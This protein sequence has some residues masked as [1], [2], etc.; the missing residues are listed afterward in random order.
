MLEGSELTEASLGPLS[1][2][3]QAQ[4]P[5]ELAWLGPPLPQ[6]VSVLRCLANHPLIL[7]QVLATLGPPSGLRQ[8]EF[9][10]ELTCCP[11]GSF[12][13]RMYVAYWG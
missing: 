5:G 1:R 8:D 2:L 10:G 13:I 6:A 9:P 7:T 11:L 12:H 3:R 4:Y